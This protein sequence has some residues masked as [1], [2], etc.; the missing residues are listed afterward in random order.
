MSKS[1]SGKQGDQ[2]AP[3]TL[4]PVIQQFLPLLALQEL[5]PGLA[6]AVYLHLDKC[7]SCADEL[8][9]YEAVTRLLRTRWKGSAHQKRQNS[10]TSSYTESNHW[11]LSRLSADPFEHSPGHTGGTAR[12]TDPGDTAPRSLHSVHSSDASGALAFARQRNEAFCLAFANA[13]TGKKYASSFPMTS[14]DP[15]HTAPDG[16]SSD[17]SSQR[18]SGNDRNE[19][20]S[21]AF[22]TGVRR[23]LA[24]IAQQWHDPGIWL[25]SEGYDPC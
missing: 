24:R 1:S 19:A 7:S 2:E 3:L 10:D 22:T 11:G 6:H 20:P 14:D 9:Q 8:E 15:E 12:E 4:C 23:S 13:L 21:D 18:L 16:D 17:E 25:P 5:R